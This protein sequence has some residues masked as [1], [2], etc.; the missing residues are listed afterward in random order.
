MAT[1]KSARR[2]PRAERCTG[3]NNPGP[4]GERVKRVLKSVQ[5][6]VQS[7]LNA[8]AHASSSGTDGPKP[9]ND[10]ETTYVSR[11]DY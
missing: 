2:G 8:R 10:D 7:F 4:G 3:S 11:G 1:A 6:R 5:G 9:L